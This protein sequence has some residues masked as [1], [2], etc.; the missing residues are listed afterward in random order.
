VRFN[1]G[2]FHAKAR[3]REVKTLVYYIGS[4]EGHESP[5]LQVGDE[6]ALL[7]KGAKEVDEMAA[8]TDVLK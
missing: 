3:S 6:D 1:R 4:A 2:R 7:A 5:D 8:E